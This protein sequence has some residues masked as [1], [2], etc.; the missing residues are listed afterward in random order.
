MSPGRRSLS[1]RSSHAPP[2][3]LATRTL[4]AYYAVSSGAV[5]LA[6][7]SV[8]IIT[9]NHLIYQ[10]LLRCVRR[11]RD[12]DAEALCIART[13]KLSISRSQRKSLQMREAIRGRDGPWACVITKYASIRSRTL[14]CPRYRNWQESTRPASCLPRVKVKVKHHH[15]HTTTVHGH[16]LASTS[17]WNQPFLPMEVP[18][19]KPA[20]IE[21]K[22]PLSPTSEPIWA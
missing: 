5:G 19:S 12:A 16:G 2:L 3:S 1:C 13:N 15:H 17:Q 9:Q 20:P 11:R 22:L 18:F 21:W 10:L 14:R 7:M 4:L 8:P 6:I